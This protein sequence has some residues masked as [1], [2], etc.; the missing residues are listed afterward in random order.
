M[1]AFAA[2]NNAR[3]NLNKYSTSTSTGISLAGNPDRNESLQNIDM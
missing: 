1:N 2:V 3:I